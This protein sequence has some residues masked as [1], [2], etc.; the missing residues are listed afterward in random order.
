MIPHIINT[1]ICYYRY[2][3]EFI[4]ICNQNIHSK[5]YK[6]VC[7]SSHLKQPGKINNNIVL[8]LKYYV[9]TYILF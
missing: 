2:K 5:S 9:T 1:I 3:K 4:T 8:N 6:L 7:V